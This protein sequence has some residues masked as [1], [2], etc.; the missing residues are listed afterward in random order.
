L[1]ARS[2]TILARSASVF[3]NDE[4]FEARARVGSVHL[5]V[6]EFVD[7]LAVFTI[8]HQPITPRSPPET[9]LVKSPHGSS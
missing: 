9:S 7:A 1:V 4:L 5:E 2:T 8:D 6:R 3:Q